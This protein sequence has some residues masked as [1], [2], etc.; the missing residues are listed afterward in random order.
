MIRENTAYAYKDSLIGD[1]NQLQ[2]SPQML[3]GQ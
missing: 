1:P 3:T 2:T